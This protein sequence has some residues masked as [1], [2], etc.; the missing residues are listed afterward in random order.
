MAKR[1]ANWSVV[2]WAKK[3]TRSVKEKRQMARRVLREKK[4]KVVVMFQK[5]G[6]I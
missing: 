2:Y 3:E 6:V 4:K 5:K 1:H